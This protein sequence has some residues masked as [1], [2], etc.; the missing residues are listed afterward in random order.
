M[1][2]NRRYYWLQLKEDFFKSKEIKLLRKLPGGEVLTIIYLKIML[3][4]LPDEG[5]IYFEGLAEDLAEELA[6]LIDEDTEAVRMAL[7]FLTKKNLLTTIDN[8][9][10]TLEQVPEMIGS[11]TASTRRSRKYREGQ[12]ALQCN[13]DA[14][15][16]N[17]DIEIDIDIE[18]DIELDQ[19]QEQ[20]NAVGGE[21]LVFKKLKEAFGEMSVNGTMVEEVERLLK[22]YGQELVVLALNETILNAGKSLRYTMSIL[23]RWDGQGL[24]TSGQIKAANEEFERKKT[25]RTQ[26]D[27]YGNIPSW[28]N[29][30]PENQKEPEPEMS[31]EEY[32][33]RLKEFLASE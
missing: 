6:L 12:K 22:Q 18:K 31:D 4:S 17:R 21:N 23:Q 29:L 32:E 20:K 26:A 14:T 5:K 27:P 25:N 33:R 28:S 10:F 9:Q 11:E 8:Y 30:R 1:A 13:T 24:R 7:M 19:E 16:R 3:A 2:V 15:K